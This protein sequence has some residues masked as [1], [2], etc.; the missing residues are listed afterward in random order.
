MIVTPTSLSAHVLEFIATR[1]QVVPSPLFLQPVLEAGGITGRCFD[2]VSR[3]VERAGGQAC[4]GWAIW[5]WPGVFIEAERHCVWRTPAGE[6]LDITK[7]KGDCRSILF[8][9]DPAGVMERHVVDNVR[10][11]LRVD[12]DLDRFLELAPL[13]RLEMAHVET[14]GQRLQGVRAQAFKANALEYNRIGKLL[15]ERYRA[16]AGKGD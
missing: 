7:P 5:E 4:I 8:Q 1:L 15:Q 2:N 13:V 12:P 3:C 16:G 6:L 14:T 11:A 9:P 10:Q